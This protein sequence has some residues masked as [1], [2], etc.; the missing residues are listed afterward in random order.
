MAHVF[1]ASTQDTPYQAEAKGRLHLPY[2]L[3]SDEKLEFAKAL[4][5]PTFEWEGK[6]V[7]KRV[8]L[9]ISEGKIDHVF[10]PVFPPGESATAVLDWL[11]QRKA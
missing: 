3:L 11:K 8:T 1:G 6:Q 9:V 4:N 10:Y 2:D 7:M 5:L